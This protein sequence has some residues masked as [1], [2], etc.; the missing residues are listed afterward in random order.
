M[1]VKKILS[2]FGSD[3]MWRAEMYMGAQQ[4]GEAAG[5]LFSASRLLDRQSCQWTGREILHQLPQSW[6]KWYLLLLEIDVFQLAF[7]S[8][9][10][11]CCFNLRVLGKAKRFGW[12]EW[13]W[14]DTA[15]GQGCCQ[16]LSLPALLW[17]QHLTGSFLL[18]HRASVQF[19]WWECNP[20]EYYLYLFRNACA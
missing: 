4:T 10:S 5:K 6:I 1:S 9:I 14:L 12:M 16:G 2:N 18:W 15:Q 19:Y 20:D 13:S 7:V 11:Q 8:W 17:K 3:H